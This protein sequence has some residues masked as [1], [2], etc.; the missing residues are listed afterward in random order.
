MTLQERFAQIAEVWPHLPEHIRLAVEVLCLQPVFCD[1]T[2]IHP[3]L[4]EPRS[5]QV[6]D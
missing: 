1:T 2:S 3:R 4:R 5:I 6:D